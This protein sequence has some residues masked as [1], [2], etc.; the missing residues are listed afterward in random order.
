MEADKALGRLKA[1]EDAR[2]AAE[3]IAEKER[4]RRLQVEE[5]LENLKK[6]TSSSSRTTEPAEAPP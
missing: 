1:A 2:N 4:G 6:R 3:R 5:E